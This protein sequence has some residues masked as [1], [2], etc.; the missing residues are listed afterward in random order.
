MRSSNDFDWKEREPAGMNEL[1]KPPLLTGGA[2]PSQFD[3][4]KRHPLFSIDGVGRTIEPPY[5][6][7]AMGV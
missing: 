7:L 2:W 5:L 1:G 6:I 3:S 4:P